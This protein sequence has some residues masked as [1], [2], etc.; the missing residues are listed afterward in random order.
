MRRN[1]VWKIK[2]HD[3]VTVPTCAHNA[4]LLALHFLT[5]Y[6][7][8]GGILGSAGHRIWSVAVRYTLWH[9]PPRLNTRSLAPCLHSHL[10]D[11][12]R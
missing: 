5:L 10:L 11:V 3:D 6:H 1:K 4:V 2:V 12:A 7:Y 8:H 9:D